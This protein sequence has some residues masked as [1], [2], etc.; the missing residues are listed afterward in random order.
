M[1]LTNEQKI[2]GK[3]N[4]FATIGSEWLQRNLLKEVNSKELKSG[5]GLGARFFGYDTIDKPVRIAVLGT[6][7]EG[8]ILIGAINP[9]YVQVV[10]I[11]DI[12]PFNQY[13][14]FH[15][16]ES[17]ANARARTGLIKKYGWKDETE[18]RSKVRVY[19]DYKELLETEKNITDPDKNIE[20]VII[21]LPLFLHAPAAIAAMKQGYHVL[22]EKLMAHSVANCKEMARAATLYKKHCAT[23]HQRHYNVLYDHIVKILQSGVLGDLHYIRAQWHR[24]N[25]PGGDSW[26][27]PVPAEIK[28]DDGELTGKLEDLLKR[29]EAKLNRGGLKP[30]DKELLERQIAQTKAQLADKILVSGGDYNGFKFKSAEQYGYKHEQL[31]IDD[32]DK[33]YDRPAAEELIR[34]RLFDRTSAGLMAELGSHQ[35][36]AASIFIAAMHGGKKQLPLSVSATATRTIFPNDLNANPIDRDVDDHVHCVYE[37]AAPNYNKN[38]E[39]GKQRKITVAY[40]SINGNGFGGYGETVLGTKGTIVIES[41][42]EAMFFDR[43]EV[44]QKTKITA[45]GAGNK[46]QLNVTRPNNGEEGDPLSAAIALQATFGDVSRGYC[47]EIEH[48]AFCIRN[49]PDAD[50]TKE[51]ELNN[52]Q[53]QK[54]KLLP[55]CYP[56]V[57]MSDAVIALTTNIAAKLGKTIDFEDTWFNINNNETPE[58]KYLANDNPELK[59]FYTPDLEKY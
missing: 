58:L 47:E 3:E 55:K 1:H 21:G 51:I 42:K 45:K 24:N 43:A 33:I 9:A 26:K 57:A 13:R 54:V 49:N 2:I 56:E 59:K 5:K 46:R 6:G 50:P 22:T 7:D 30:A 34:W 36:D 28:P 32:S 14:A 41:E 29:Q 35:L 27:Q 31:K 4:F 8:G 18:A 37:Y 23:G 16:D 48:W 25:K 12:R 38:D 11:A 53:K 17:S 20:A 39:L 44:N 10:A 19:G 52:P 15:G 40:S